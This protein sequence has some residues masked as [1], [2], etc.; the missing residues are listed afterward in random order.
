MAKHRGWLKTESTNHNLEQN[1]QYRNISTSR[2][3]DRIPCERVWSRNVLDVSIKTWISKTVFSIFLVTLGAGSTGVIAE[4]SENT[5]TKNQQSIMFVHGAHLSAGGWSKVRSILDGEGV[6]TYAVNLPGRSKDV[7]PNS[8]T[9][10]VAAQGLCDGLKKVDGEIM[11][12]AHSQGGAVVN[13]SLSVCPD[14]N[15]SSIV[16]LT[17]AAAQDGETMISMLSKKDKQ[18]YLSG[19]SLDKET[20]WMVITD[21]KKFTHSFATDPTPEQAA[22]LLKYAV[23]EP[24]VTGQGKVKLPA[25]EYANIDK[26]YIFTEDDQIISLESQKTIAANIELVDEAQLA[27]GHTPMVT[28]PEELASV[29]EGFITK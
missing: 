25:E 26:Y 20:G 18:H 29:L 17:A 10:D 15:I 19:V 7:D 5:S 6:K 2:L 1:M 11:I 3:I 27:T 14:E 28:A 23:D 16:Y 24:A 13:D 22:E 12:V 4:E 9:L 8:I 21:N